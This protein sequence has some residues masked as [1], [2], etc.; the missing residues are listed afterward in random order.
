MKR[1]SFHCSLF[2][3]YQH[4]YRIDIRTANLHHL[5]YQYLYL[6]YLITKATNHERVV[7]Q[8]NLHHNLI[9]TRPQLRLL[10]AT[11]CDAPHHIASDTIMSEQFIITEKLNV[12]WCHPTILGSQVLT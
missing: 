10:S 7:G 2:N 6:L 4:C 12:S 8:C 1:H 5:L 11:H 3:F 9:S